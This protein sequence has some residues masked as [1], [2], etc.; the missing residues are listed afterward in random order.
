ML[1]AI[2]TAKVAISTPAAS[3]IGFSATRSAGVARRQ[4]RISRTATAIEQARA[5]AVDREQHV[6]ERLRGKRLEEV[7]RTRAALARGRWM[8]PSSKSSPTKGSTPTTA[9]DAATTRSARVVSLP[10]GNA[11]RRCARN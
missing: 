9:I 6:R 4:R 5:D 8:S 7:L 3:T 2:C 1:T 10:L 11:S